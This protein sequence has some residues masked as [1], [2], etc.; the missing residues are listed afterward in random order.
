M[1]ATVRDV[2]PEI[3]TELRKVVDKLFPDDPELK[4]K[5]LALYMQNPLLKKL[6]EEAGFEVGDER[7]RN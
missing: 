7:S 6:Y 2:D 1:K 4:A 3:K 5:L